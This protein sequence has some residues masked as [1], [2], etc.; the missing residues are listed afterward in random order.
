MTCDHKGLMY[1]KPNAFKENKHLTEIGDVKVLMIERI[2]IC[3][4]C[5]KP[6][7]EVSYIEKP[8]VVEVASEEELQ[9]F[10][11]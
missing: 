4:E 11:Y 2:A 10:K 1:Y 8:E 3:G 5:K 9:R 7:V 6:T